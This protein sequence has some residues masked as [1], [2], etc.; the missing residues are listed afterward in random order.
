MLILLLPYPPSVNTYW[1]FKGSHRYLTDKAKAF[2]QEV[3][4]RFLE[5][6]HKGFGSANL[7]LKVKLHPRDNRIRDIDN[8]IK[9]LLDAMCQAGIYT[10]D[11]QIQKLEIEKAG[12]V[13]GGFCQIILDHY[14]K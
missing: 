4:I 10:D 8:G 7:E 3:W 11:S 5:S 13:K 2:K 12:I 1:G 14:Q 9:S 6:G